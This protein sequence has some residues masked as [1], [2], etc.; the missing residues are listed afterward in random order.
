MRSHSTLTSRVAQERSGKPVGPPGASVGGSSSSSSNGAGASQ[1]AGGG[2]SGLVPVAPEPALSSS[3]VAEPYEPTITA[4][5]DGKD[6]V[7]DTLDG[8]RHARAALDL[9]SSLLGTAAAD[10]AAFKLALFSGDDSSYQGGSSFDGGDGGT[11]ISFDASDSA[12]LTE[13]MKRLGLEDEKPVARRG[14]K[15]GG[16]KEEDDEDD[17][18]A[19]M[20]AAVGA[21]D[22]KK[23]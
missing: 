2:N 10:G 19:M 9:L 12:R 8:G 4:A 7:E 17:L 22:S 3:V 6:G 11:I 16:G 18:L 20:D 14:V 5:T 23:K 15:A 1:G 21:S 13:M